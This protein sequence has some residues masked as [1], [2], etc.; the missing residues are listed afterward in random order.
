M[1]SQ[2]GGGASKAGE[3]GGGEQPLAGGEVAEDRAAAD[4]GQVGDLVDGGGQA[5]GGQGPL[6]RLHDACP[7][8]VALLVEERRLETPFG[9]PSDA[10]LIGKIEEHFVVFL[11]RHGRGHRIPPSEINFRANIDA[12]KRSGAVEQRAVDAKDAIVGSQASLCGYA[13]INHS[14]N[15][16]A[17]RVRLRRTQGNAEESLTAQLAGWTISIA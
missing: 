11:S 6:R 2:R 4:A 12:L 9:E 8:P 7:R 3:E 1:F 13:G 15:R 14:L 17:G 5:P 16:D 10:F